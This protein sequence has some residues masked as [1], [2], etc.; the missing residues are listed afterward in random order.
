MASIQFDSTEILNSTYNPRFVKHESNPDRQLNSAELTRED[1]EAFISEKFGKK[2]IQLQGVLVGTSQAD[3]ESKIN[4]FKELFS[5]PEKNLDI[6]W[7]GSTIRYVATCTSHLFDRDH[8]HIAFVPWTAEFTVLSGEG[9]DTSTTTAR[10]QQALTTTT[11]VTDSFTFSG[12]KPGKP[13]ITIQGNN[14]TGAT[15][16]IEYL[17]TDT[18]EKIVITRNDTWGTTDTIKI[19]CATRKVTGNLNAL[20]YTEYPF[21]G[22]FPSFRIGTNNVQISVGGIVNQTTSELLASNVGSGSNVNATTRK[23]AQ[24]FTVPYTD[25]TFQGITLIIAKTGSPGTITWKIETDT[26]GSPS[27]SQ[28][29]NAN[30]TIAAASVSTT[31]YVTA[32][33]SSVWTL[34]ANTRYWI[35]VTAASVDGSNFYTFYTVPNTPSLYPVYTKGNAK[36]SSDSGSTYTNLVSATTSLCFKVRYGGQ[37][38]T[39]GVKHSVVYTRTYL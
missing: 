13:L 22:V 20:I 6:D 7:N 3:L 4:T 27:G 5:R 10:N 15:K 21:Y 18:N 17:N 35:T 8:F 28:V 31:A 19:D 25:S 16:G 29:T 34:S 37:P 2:V 26:N 14:F 12:S 23:L 32:Y 36:E 1:G 11:P 39:S 9:K 30:G 38:Q 24:S 33:S